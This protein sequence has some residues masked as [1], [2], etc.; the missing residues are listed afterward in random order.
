[1]GKTLRVAATCLHLA[2]SAL[3]VGACGSSPTSDQPEIVTSISGLVY[4]RETGAPLSMASVETVPVS[5]AVST[6]SDGRYVITT[7]VEVGKQYAVVASKAGYQQDSRS[8][9]V[10]EGKNANVDIGLMAIAGQLVVDTQNIDVRVLGDQ[11]VD[12]FFTVTNAGDGAMSWSLA[13]DAKP[14]MTV[15]TSG[16]TLGKAQS[17]TVVVGADGAKWPSTTGTDSSEIRITSVAGNAVIAV[18]FTKVPAECPL[19][20][21]DPSTIVGFGTTSSLE[22]LYVQNKGNATMAWSL[23]ET[24]PWLEASP[25]SGTTA[26]GQTSSVD[27]VLDRSLITTPGKV[28]TSIVV[29]A[30]SPDNDACGSESHSVTVEATKLSGSCVP[31]QTVCQDDFT[32]MKCQGDGSGWLTET[33]PAGTYCTEDG[34]DRCVDQVCQP[35]AVYCKDA[36]TVAVCDPT[37]AAES[38]YACG[39]GEWCQNGACVCKASCLHNGVQKICGS[40]GCGGVCGQCTVANTKCQEPEGICVEVP[41]YEVSCDESMPHGAG[42]CLV[43]SFVETASAVMP[44][45]GCLAVSSGYCLIADTLSATTPEGAEAASSSYRLDS[46]LIE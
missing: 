34:T 40:D 36:N 43:G 11:K 33:C 21:V 22:K 28:S 17:E 12:K 39:A 5:Q 8:V 29:I 24:S 14:W 26:P 31:G 15:G 32:L 27:L 10:V 45:T 38:T 23:S 41:K 9:S 37:G 13:Y 42:V 44:V 30:S 20:T 4:D 3:F 16:G 1:M 46:N 18:S 19:L 6:G 35:D 2:S 25:A 7:N